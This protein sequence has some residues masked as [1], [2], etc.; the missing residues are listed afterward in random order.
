MQKVQRPVHPYFNDFVF[1][2][3]KEIIKKMMHW[4]L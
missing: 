1:D 4:D 2:G 3:E